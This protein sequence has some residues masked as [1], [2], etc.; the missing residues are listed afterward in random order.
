MS[1]FETEHK[2]DITADAC[3]I[4]FV[5]TKLK[6][7][8]LSPGELLEVIINDGEPLQNVPRSVKGEG[9]KILSLENIDG[10]KYRLIIE[11]G[12]E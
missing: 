8:E 1:K 4:T 10:I 6:L 2:I 7:E 9:H 5:K 12:E 11:K 3:P